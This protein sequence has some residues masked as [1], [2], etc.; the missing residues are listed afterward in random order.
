[1]E[2]DEDSD[3][4]ELHVVKPGETPSKGIKR[5]REDDT[6]DDFSK[7]RKVDTK[8]GNDSN[9]KV[10]L[11]NLAFDLEGK[12]DEIK[13]HFSDC[14]SIKNV[15][16]ITRKDGSFA[17]VAIVEFETSEGASSAL[18]KNEEEF[19]GRA[20]KVTYA[21]E[22]R[23]G[24]GGKN[25]GPSEKPEGCTTVFIGNLSYQI[26]EDKVYEFFSGC[27]NV[28]EIRWNPGDFK[29]YGWVEFEDTNSPDEAMKLNGQDIAGRA[30]RIDYAAPKKKR[31]W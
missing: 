6:T 1:M 26:T 25:K 7:K 9:T 4:E 15:E 16:F 31:E 20:M 22:E 3:S 13:E 10:R 12:E 2:T 30:I 5:K 29:G 14:G 23:K 27:G 24:G 28:K 21:Q 8:G 17:G 18:S 19:H 11:G